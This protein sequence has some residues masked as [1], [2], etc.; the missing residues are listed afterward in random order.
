[1]SNHRRIIYERYNSTPVADRGPTE[2][3]IREQSY[4]LRGWLPT[5][6]NAKC[7][8]VGCGAGAFVKLLLDR[9]FTDV[10]GCDISAEQVAL[11]C[12][13]GLPC[14]A[15]D[16]VTALEGANAEYDLI[17]AFDVIEHFSKAELMRFLEATSRSLK[18]GGA[19]ILK[20]PNA[21][22]P[23]G[24]SVRYGDFTHEVGLTPGSLS[25]LLRLFGFEDIQ[26]REVGPIPH[27]LKSLLR[28]MGWWVIRGAFTALEYIE[29]GAPGAPVKTRV[30]LSRAVRGPRSP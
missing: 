1:M 7:L 15:V 27:G 4:F 28:T 25:H 11:A 3:W 9:G 17:T 6:R 8:D 5:G 13:A 22:S 10:A 21:S 23:M 14:T 24:M 12:G 2:Q 26:F 29:T 19:L 30:M 16:A 18:P 20:S